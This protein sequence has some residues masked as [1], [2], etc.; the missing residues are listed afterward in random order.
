MKGRK[1]KDT[2]RKMEGRKKGR[3]QDSIRL[4]VN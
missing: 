4:K 2:D 3:N 1:K